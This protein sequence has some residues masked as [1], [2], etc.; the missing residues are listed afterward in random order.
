MSADAP[1]RQI[2]AAEA[3]ELI[4]AEPIRVL[5]VRSPE[6][7]ANLGHIPGADLLPVDLIAAAAATLPDR[8]ESILVCCEH[9][10]SAL[11]VLQGGG[12]HELA[13]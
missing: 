11:D 8:D 3:Q 4:R 13:P 5:D 2:D 9:G 12:P 10:V 1:Y 7:Y 6:E